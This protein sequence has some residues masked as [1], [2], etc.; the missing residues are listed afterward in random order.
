M[1]D[2]IEGPVNCGWIKQHRS[3]LDNP[4]FTDG[5][6]LKVWTFLLLSATHAAMKM[7]F[8][9]EV[10]TLRLGQAITSRQSTAKSTGVQESKVE[11][12]FCA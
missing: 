6:W 11:R 4:R 1:R 10:V 9:G 5:D 3:L 12:I 8:R 2:T 7:V